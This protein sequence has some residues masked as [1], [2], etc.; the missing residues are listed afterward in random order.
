MPFFVNTL[1]CC[2]TPADFP[3]KMAAIAAISGEKENILIS[4]G[5][6]HPGGNTGDSDHQCLL[7]LRIRLITFA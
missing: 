5:V 7:Y 6:A 4:A 3:S 1:L 2:V